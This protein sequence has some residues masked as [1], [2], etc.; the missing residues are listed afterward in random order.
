MR[1]LKKRSRSFCAL[2]PFTI[3]TRGI[4]SWYG[5][6]GEFGT[7]ASGDE[8]KIAN[9]CII[10]LAV[11]MCTPLDGCWYVIA[12]ISLGEEEEGYRSL[13]VHKNGDWVCERK[14]GKTLSVF[15]ITDLHKYSHSLV[16][17]FFDLQV[18]FFH[19]QWKVK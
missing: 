5:N 14:A 1:N 13:C 6:I 2:T 9:E 11:S 8:Y 3:I 7:E 4:R 17:F 12:S 10:R 18:A 15:S 19:R 16:A